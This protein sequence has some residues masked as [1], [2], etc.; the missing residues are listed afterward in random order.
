MIPKMGEFYVFCIDFEQGKE[1]VQ[2][3]LHRQIE[4]DE[5]TISTYGED[6]EEW[7]EANAKLEEKKRKLSRQIELS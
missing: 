6:T 2:E 4:C 7:K 3:E 5:Y 1:K